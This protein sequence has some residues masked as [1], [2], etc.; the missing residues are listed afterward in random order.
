[1]ENVTSYLDSVSDFKLSCAES[2]VGCLIAYC[3]E[4]KL[5]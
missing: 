1:M 2:Y 4:F 5:I 3:L